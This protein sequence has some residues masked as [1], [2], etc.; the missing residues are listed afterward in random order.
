MLYLFSHRFIFVF[1]IATIS[2]T[3]SYGG[4]DNPIMLSNPSPEEKNYQTIQ[5]ELFIEFGKIKN[6]QTA[7]CTLI[8]KTIAE[9]TKLKKNS[10]FSAIFTTFDDI[11]DKILTLTPSV[12]RSSEIDN[13]KEKDVSENTEATLGSSCGSTLESSDPFSVESINTINT[14]VSIYTNPFAHDQQVNL[15]FEEKKEIKVAQPPAIPDTPNKDYEENNPFEENLVVETESITISNSAGSS[16][17]EEIKNNKRKK[18][19]SFLLRL[20]CVGPVK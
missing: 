16:S 7:K 6:N 2:F 19:N 9:N 8:Q 18:S 4:G 13:Q 5:R 10:G 17:D 11:K 20:F 15:N 14:N 3:Q 12:E 1:L